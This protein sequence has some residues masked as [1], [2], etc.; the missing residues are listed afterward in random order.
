MNFIEYLNSCGWSKISTMIWLFLSLWKEEIIFLPHW[1]IFTLFLNISVSYFHLQDW[2]Y[3]STPAYNTPMF[4]V[5]NLSIHIWS[6][7]NSTAMN[8]DECWIKGYFTVN[9]FDLEHNCYSGKYTFI[10]YIY[11]SFV[12]EDN[13]QS[14]KF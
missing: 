4:I 1:I 5:Y 14:I 6:C 7:G 8:F 13:F 3:N 10:L 9:V 2:F 12:E 11:F